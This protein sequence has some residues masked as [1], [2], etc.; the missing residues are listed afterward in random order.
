MDAPIDKRSSGTVAI[1]IRIC[2]P[3]KG[4]PAGSGRCPAK[5]WLPDGGGE[6]VVEIKMQLAK[7][8]DAVATC[9]V[10]RELRL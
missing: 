4:E 1:R 5:Q 10:D 2:V 7:N 8:A 9:P 6:N 3:L